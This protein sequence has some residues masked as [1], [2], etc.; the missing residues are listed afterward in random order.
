MAE[1]STNKER[2]KEITASIEASIQDLFQS[3]RY[4]DYLRT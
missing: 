4:M 2:L 3:E 1:N